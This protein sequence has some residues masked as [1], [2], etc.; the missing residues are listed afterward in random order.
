MQIGMIG[1]G[2]MGM[3]MAKRWIIAKHDVVVY[4]RTASKVE[5]IVKDGAVGTTTLEDFVK[6][7]KGPRIVWLMLPTGPV[8]EEHLQKLSQLL[9]SGDMVIDGGNS[10]FKDDLR[11]Y[12]ELKKKGNSLFGR[13]RLRR[14]LG[15]QT[16][17]LHDGRR[18]RN[19]LQTLGAIAERFG[20]QRRISVLR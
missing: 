17:L 11:H 7:L 3:N 8:L 5:D 1:L 10:Y 19:G 9:S 2:R 18:R 12:D 4:N 14:N 16:R 13:R 15:T 6:K 20:A